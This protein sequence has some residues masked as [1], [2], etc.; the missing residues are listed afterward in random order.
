M[1]S[2]RGKKCASYS[3]SSRGNKLRNREKDLDQI[4]EE[5][6]KSADVSLENPKHARCA[7]CDRVFDAKDM[8]K[9]LASAGHKRRVR[10]LHEDAL[11]AQEQAEIKT[12]N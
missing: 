5:I 6:G 2:S 3:R 10:D 8:R 7:T 1:K 4:R 11:F 12:L 9:H